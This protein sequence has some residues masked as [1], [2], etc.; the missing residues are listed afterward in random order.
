MVRKDYIVEIKSW[1]DKI[2]GNSY[3]SGRIYDSYMR[4]LHVM[5]FQYGYGRHSEDVA[6]VL[7]QSSSEVHEN[8]HDLWRKCYFNHQEALKRDTVSFGKDLNG[9][10]MYD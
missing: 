7:I 3:F 2:N 8:R 4:L 1:F 6:T 9:E 5:P 10:A